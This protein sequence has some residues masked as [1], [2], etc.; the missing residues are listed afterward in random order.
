MKHFVCNCGAIDS[1]YNNT[2]NAN[3]IDMR[4]T[5]AKCVIHVS[6]PWAPFTNMD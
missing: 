2:M 6:I 3:V 5:R 1:G 4:D